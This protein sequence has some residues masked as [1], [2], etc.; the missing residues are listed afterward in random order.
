LTL[1]VDATRD[2]SADAHANSLERI[3]LRLWE[4]D[5]TQQIVDL[6]ERSA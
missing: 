6:L 5:T 2:N 3:F 4:T 1:A